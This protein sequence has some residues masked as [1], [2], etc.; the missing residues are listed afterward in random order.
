VKNYCALVAN[1]TVTEIIVGDIDW[2]TENLQGDWHDLGP[3]PL[4]VA[5]GWIYDAATDTFSAPPTP[6]P[7]D[8][9]VA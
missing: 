9:S 6:E 8:D 4:T 2:A 3:E 5:I 7:D 1:S